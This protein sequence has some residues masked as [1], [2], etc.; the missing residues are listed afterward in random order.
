[1]KK[2]ETPSKRRIVGRYVPGNIGFGNIGTGEH[3][4]ARDPSKLKPR[5]RDKSQ[6]HPAVERI[7]HNYF[8]LLGTF[9]GPAGVHL[10]A[11]V[12]S[13]DNMQ[14]NSHL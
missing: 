10:D 3:R 9:L 5:H 1:M 12:T 2:T 14:N 8:M 11:C 4:Y 7:V 13:R 6:L